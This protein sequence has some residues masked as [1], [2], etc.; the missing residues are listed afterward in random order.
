MRIA[1]GI[2]YQ[3]AGFTGWQSQPSGL[4]VQDAFEAALARFIGA[5]H[6][7]AHTPAD[8]PR[9]PTVCAG[10]TDAGVHATAQVLHF[11]SPVQRDPASW[12][13]GLNTFLPPTIAVHWAQAVSDDFHARFAAQ[14]REYVYVIHDD[15]VRP[16]QLAPL[17]GWSFR[18]LDAA[19]MHRAAQCL[20]GEHDFSAFRAAECQA[21]SPIKQLHFINVR[22]H[23]KFV[24]VRVR[25]N[26][27]LHHM[28]RNIVGSLV[29]V[30]QGRWP[31]DRLAQVL[32]GRSRAQAAP[33]FA[34]EGLY[35][36]GVHY[37]DDFGVPD[38]AD[39]A[40]WFAHLA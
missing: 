28:V 25:A 20:P 5:P 2:S 24:L 13:R 26:A 27:F 37:P 23:G 35:L 29:Y 12:V 3:G 8:L 33:T 11:D 21:K 22:R 14:W 1:L 30:G 36:T 16:V 9:W 19:A 18:P 31:E 34:A 15:P 39:P 6:G 7:L 10:R 4:G 38:A 40:P 32:A 17:V